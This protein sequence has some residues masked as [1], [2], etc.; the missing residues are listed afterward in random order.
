MRI[1]NLPSPGFLSNSTALR[2]EACSA[3]SKAEIQLDLSPESDIADN[4]REFFLACAAACPGTQKPTK[5]VT[6]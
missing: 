4:L 3:I 5:K 2:R 6:K 1:E